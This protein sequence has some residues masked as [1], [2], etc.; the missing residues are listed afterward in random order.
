MYDIAVI[1]CPSYDRITRNSIEIPGRNLSGP[2][3]TTAV[4]AT[5]LAIE[6]MVIIGSISTEFSSQLITDYENLGIPEYYIIESPETGG[7]EIECNDGEEPAFTSVLG[8]PKALG[9]RD[10]PDEFLSSKIIILSP[11]LQ[12]VD[13]ELVEWICSSSDS[14][15]LMDPQIKTVDENR[16]LTIISELFVESKTRSF[17]DYIIP[18]EHDAFLI[19]GEADPF[20]AAEIIVDS[21]A[22]HCIITLDSQGSLI[23]DGK[24]FSIIPSQ[25]IEVCDVR[26][27]EPAFVA[28][29]AYGLLDN[30]AA[31]DCAALGTATAGFKLLGNGIDFHLD[32]AQVRRRAAEISL[33]IETR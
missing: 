24:I 31:S 4:T 2:A 13:T 19:T 25:T 7:F 29:F 27:A 9:I 32:S 11:L 8:I 14:L 18:N 20:L 23:Y 15:I 3:V 30:Q 21:I 1:G 17:I 26:G 16:K 5:K 33:D 10:I 6:N 12:E 22:D 28:G